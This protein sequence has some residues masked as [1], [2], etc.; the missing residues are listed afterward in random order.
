[1]KIV[2][3]P[4]KDSITLPWIL[5]LTLDLQISNVNYYIYTWIVSVIFLY[6]LKFLLCL[7]PVNVCMELTLMAFIVTVI[8]LKCLYTKMLYSVLG[9]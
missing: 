2:Y 4:K 1:M 5:N 7:V 6:I 8:Q 9:F 3:I